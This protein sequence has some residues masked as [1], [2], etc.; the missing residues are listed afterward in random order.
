MSKLA[1]L[2]VLLATLARAE[3]HPM[4][5]RQAVEAALR[6]NPDVFLAHMEEDKARAG[7]RIAR[8]HFIPRVVF[9]SGL[10]YSDGF[11]MSIEG[12]AP[13]VIQGNAIASVYNRQQQLE[14]AQA[15]EDARGAAIA[16]T[17]KRDDVAYRTTLLYLDAER[18]SRLLAMARRA[19]AS[20][21]AVLDAVHAQVAEGR[22]LP[23]AEKQ[24]ALEVARAEQLVES[25]E[26]DAASAETSLAIALGLPARDRV[27]PVEQERPAPA[28]PSS[29]EDAV[30]S[31]I[32]SRPEVRQLQSQLLSKELE[33]RSEKAAR[34]PHADL[35]A[36]YGMLARF[37]NYAEFF[38]KF[39]RN[40]GQ[41]GVSFQLPIYDPAVNAEV[42]QTDADLNHLRVELASAR[43]RIAGDIAQ[44]FRDVRKAESAAKV[45]RLDLDV[46]RAQ[47]DVD[48][49]QQQEGRLLLRDVEAAR[50]SEDEKW[51]AFYDAQFTVEK[52]RWAVLRVTGGLT[53]AVA[54]L[55]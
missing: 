33:R 13:S 35:V 42:S 51:I 5:L 14:V 15:R 54:A 31:A 24:A 9:G 40:N 8:E 19:V 44:A 50:L 6:Q 25:L 21:Q 55:Q 10:A 30:Q 37:N 11:P 26:D 49:A 23:L 41:I 34:L 7:I 18:A 2:F 20:R 38:Q 27:Q 39:Q 29:E 45:A 46:A 12:S 1:G 43:N 16:V 28:L 48:L 36:Q 52:A 4:T 22:A 32:E 47:L 53:K 3:T 17:A